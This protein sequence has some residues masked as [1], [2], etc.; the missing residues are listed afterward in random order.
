[1]RA[2]GPASNR[3]IINTSQ[4]GMAWWADHVFTTIARVG[5][6]LRRVTGRAIDLATAQAN[7]RIAADKHEKGNR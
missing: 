4:S 2:L 1:M 3:T 5:G 7:C 6:E